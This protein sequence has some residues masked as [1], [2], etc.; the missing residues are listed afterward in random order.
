MW[1]DISD[2]EGNC[3]LDL[4]FRLEDLQPGINLVR[5]SLGL[6]P[7]DDNEA[8]YAKKLKSLHSS[9]RSLK[10]KGSKPCS[11]RTSTYTKACVGR[12]RAGEGRPRDGRARSEAD[13][14]RDAL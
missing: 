1:P 4:I 7:L 14:R 3:L 5:E 10:R 12:S 11:R 9:R 8:V 2:D 6:P 13:I